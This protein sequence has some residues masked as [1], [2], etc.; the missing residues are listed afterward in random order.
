MISCSKYLWVVRHLRIVEPYLEREY[1]H[2]LVLRLVCGLCILLKVYTA[3]GCTENWIIFYAN[4]YCSGLF[5]LLVGN[6][7][8]RIMSVDLT[9]M[10]TIGTNHTSSM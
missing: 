4:S 7:M 2:T 5:T 10:E 3:I 8:S 9:I 6:V 1:F